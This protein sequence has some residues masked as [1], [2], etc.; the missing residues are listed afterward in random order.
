[1]EYFVLVK[2]QM[3]RPVQ[4]GGSEWSII[5]EFSFNYEGPK[6]GISIQ[7]WEFP[8]SFLSKE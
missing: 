4:V 7:D 2:G 3:R 1:M 5:S 6:D 8:L